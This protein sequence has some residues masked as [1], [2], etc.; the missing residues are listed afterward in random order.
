MLKFY[1]L[2]QLIMPVGLVNGN[3]KQIDLANHD[4]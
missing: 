1:P 4:T 3:M 2:W